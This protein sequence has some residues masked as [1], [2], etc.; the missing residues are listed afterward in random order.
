MT[1][2]VCSVAEKWSR[3]I[4]LFFYIGFVEFVSKK[5]AAECNVTSTV[6]VSEKSCMFK[7]LSDHLI[8]SFV[9]EPFFPLSHQSF[10]I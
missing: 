4:Y 2:E 5:D 6:A 10:E 1:S 7:V 9:A 3:F 8:R